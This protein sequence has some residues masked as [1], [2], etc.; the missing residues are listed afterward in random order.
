MK[1]PR[2]PQKSKKDEV[3]A[4]IYK[5]RAALLP[6]INTQSARHLLLKMKATQPE[7]EK[8]SIPLTEEEI[9]KRHDLLTI[10]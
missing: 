3:D 8:I 4:E 9:R 7:F 6:F 5:Q 10:I 1:D 2:F